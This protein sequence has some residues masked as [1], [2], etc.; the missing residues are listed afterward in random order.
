M[1]LQQRPEQS[2]QYLASTL[3]CYEQHLSK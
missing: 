1:Q 3:S 2:K